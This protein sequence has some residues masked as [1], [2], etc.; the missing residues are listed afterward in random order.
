MGGT[1]HFSGNTH[2]GIITTQRLPGSISAHLTLT[3][4]IFKQSKRRLSRPRDPI[5]ALY[6]CIKNQLLTR[7]FNGTV[8][9]RNPA[10]QLRLVV[11]SY[12]IIYRGFIH[13][14]WLAGFLNHQQYQSNQHHYTTS[15]AFKCPRYSVMVRSTMNS[16]GATFDAVNV[17]T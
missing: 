10:N 7:S 1:H 8:D 2:K 4:Q 12:P 15:A 16:M 3:K 13:P 17:E 11:L 5:A 14:R 6:L 9:G